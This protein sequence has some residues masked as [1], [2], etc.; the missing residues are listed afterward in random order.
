MKCSITSGSISYQISNSAIKDHGSQAYRN[1]EMARER[2]SF[3]FDPSEILLSR[4]MGFSFVRAAVACA[5]IERISGLEP[6]S[7]TTAP[8]NVK[9]AF[10]PLSL[11]GYHWCCLSSVWSSRHRSPSYT[12]RRFRRDFPLGLLPPALPQLELVC[13]R[14]TTDW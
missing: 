12:L 13:H 2:I 6:S 5:I 1:M 4:Q 11:F 3:T 7:E 14:Q 9:L 10:L 8:R